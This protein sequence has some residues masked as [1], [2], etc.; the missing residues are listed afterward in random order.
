[1]N[2]LQYSIIPCN[3][4]FPDKSL[5][6]SAASLKADF[7]LVMHAQEDDGVV[8]SD[9]HSILLTQESSNRCSQCTTST[10]EPLNTEIQ[11]SWS[12]KGVGGALV[13]YAMKEN[14]FLVSFESICIL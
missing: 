5:K 12:L 1:M 14:L 11:P 7:Y 13:D 8:A 4:T 3:K 2:V 10:P 9:G 6:I